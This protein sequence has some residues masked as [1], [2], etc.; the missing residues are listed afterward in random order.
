LEILQISNSPQPFFVLSIYEKNI[1]LINLHTLKIISQ[2]TLPDKAIC[3][4][5]I[6]STKV[7]IGGEKSLILINVIGLKLS[8]EKQKMTNQSQ[9]NCIGWFPSEKCAVT[10]SSNGSLSLWKFNRSI[11]DFEIVGNTYPSTNG[12][13][14]FIWSLFCLPKKGIVAVTNNTDS[15]VVFQIIFDKKQI[16]EIQVLKGFKSKINSLN[17]INKRILLASHHSSDYIHQI[18]IS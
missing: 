7:L 9:I 11:E 14:P 16:E 5:K 12:A 8:I 17:P 2:T 6:S 15:V 10:G 18:E 1:F 4:K 3:S 13:N